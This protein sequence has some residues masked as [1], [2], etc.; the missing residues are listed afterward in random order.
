MAA[1]RAAGRR[2]GD[3]PRRVRAGALPRLR[4]RLPSRRDPQPGDLGAIA[5][6]APGISAGRRRADELAADLDLDRRH[7]ATPP[8]RRRRLR[9]RTAPGDAYAAPGATLEP[10]D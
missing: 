10:D 3:A 2:E 8:G 6:A 9:R 5:N 7:D 1:R 4:L